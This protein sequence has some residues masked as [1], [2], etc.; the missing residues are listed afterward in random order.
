MRTYNITHLKQLESEAIFVMRE[1]AAQ[2]ERPALLFSGGKDSIVMAH[3]AAKAFTPA[4]MPFP[5]VHVDTGHNFPETLEYR[6]R[7]VEKVGGRLLVGLVQ[8]SIDRGTA[9]E[10]AGVNPS[11]NALQSVTLL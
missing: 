8:D 7:F 3:L 6:D 9:Q 11:R 5:L 1:T 10:E 2:F 4:K